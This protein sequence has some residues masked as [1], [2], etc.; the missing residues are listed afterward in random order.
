VL[1][2]LRDSKLARADKIVIEG[3]SLGA[4]TAGM[5]AAD[6]TTLAGVIMISG[7][8]DLLAALRHPRAMPAWMLAMRNGIRLTGRGGLASRSVLTVARRIKSP[9]LLINGAMDDRTD[10]AHASHLA[11][12]IDSAGGHA[13]FVLVPDYGHRIPP[14]VRARIVDPFLAA[15]LGARAP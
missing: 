11:A 3:V 9:V 1:R 6:D 8:Y 15:V 14:E 10:P 5:L 13:R 4:M 2:A 7:E 12:A